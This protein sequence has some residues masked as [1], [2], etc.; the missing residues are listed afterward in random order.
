MEAKTRIILDTD[1]NNELD[2]QHALAYLLFNGDS[3]DLEGVTINATERGGTV[4]DHYAEAERILK[5]ST[6]HP[7]IPLLKGAGGSFEEIR[8]HLE[9]PEFD[10]A[11]AVDFIAECA[12]APSSRKLVLLAVGKLTNVALAYQKNLRIAENAWLVWLGSNY[13]APGEYNQDNDVAAMNFLLDS[14]LPFS[15]ALVRYGEPSGTDA[16]RAELADVR[17]RMPGLG[18]RS[19]EPVMGRHGVA[20]STFGDYSV[21]LFENADYHGGP[22]S[23]ALYDMAAVA[24][25]KNPAWAQARRIPAPILRDGVWSERPDNPRHI[26]LWENFDKEAIMADF[27]RTMEDYVLV[28][29]GPP[30]A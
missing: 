29:T 17:R 3:F 26:E 4:D 27:Y 1:T 28:S 5:L 18:P 25:V 9:E 23:R 6:L 13:P 10:G 24:V 22:P 16:V 21:N 11:D 20:F 8:D 12:L 15:I 14:D 2:D 7:E 30:S 19:E